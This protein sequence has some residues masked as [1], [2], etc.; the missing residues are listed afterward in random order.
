MVY[1]AIVIGYCL[2]LFL[3]VRLFHALHGW[4]EDVRA[5]TGEMR[6][7]ITKRAA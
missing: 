5:M 1:L 7:G 6:T 4:D 2:L 3:M